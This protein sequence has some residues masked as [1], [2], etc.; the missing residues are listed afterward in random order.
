MLLLFERDNR[1]DVVGLFGI[2][3]KCLFGILFDKFM[4]SL[5]VVFFLIFEVDI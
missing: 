4:V 5:Y 3:S 1:I 2:F